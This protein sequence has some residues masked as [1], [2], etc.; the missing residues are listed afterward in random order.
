MNDYFDLDSGNPVNHLT[1]NEIDRNLDSLISSEPPDSEESSE[2]ER[3]DRR[4]YNRFLS[5]PTMDLHTIGLRCRIVTSFSLLP[6]RRNHM[7]VDDT[8]RAV[9]NSVSNY[10]AN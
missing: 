3:S 5:S 6:F 10:V 8:Q 1:V 7:S 2:A 4:Q 9:R